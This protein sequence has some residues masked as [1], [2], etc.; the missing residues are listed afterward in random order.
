LTLDGTL[1][2]V[3]IK[4]TKTFDSG[5]PHMLFHTR[6]PPWEGPPGIPTNSYAVSK[7]GRLF[8][9]NGAAGDTTAAQITL[10]TNWQAGLR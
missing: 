3:G 7:D 10:A 5:P 4:G 1:M 9:I 8:L 6:I 2:V